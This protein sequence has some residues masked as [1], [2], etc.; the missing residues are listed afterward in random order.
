MIFGTRT[1]FAVSLLLF[2]AVHT[3]AQE[4]PVVRFRAVTPDGAPVANAP[5]FWTPWSENLR[6]TF[7][8]ESERSTTDADGYCTVDFSSHPD[9]AGNNFEVCVE[10]APG[11]AGIVRV[12]PTEKKEGP[13]LIEV[14]KQVP[15]RGRVRAED[16]TPIAGAVLGS[17]WF[18]RTTSDEEGR[19]TV[20]GLG[21]SQTLSVFKD[22]FAWNRI[23]FAK[24]EVDIVLQPGYRITIETVDVTGQSVAGAE[25]RYQ[26][27]MVLSDTEGR[28]QTLPLAAGET[29]HIYA[30]FAREP[31]YI[32]SAPTQ[33]TVVAGQ[34]QVVRLVLTEPERVPPVSISGRVV[35]AG[36]GEPVRARIFAHTAAGEFDYFARERA[37][38]DDQGNFTIVSVSKTEQFL[39]ARPTKSTLYGQDGIVRV[40]CREG[41]VDGIVLNV[42]LG[43]AISGRVTLSDGSNPVPDWVLLSHGEAVQQFYAET[44]HFQFFN[45][46][47]QPT[48]A[49]LRKGDIS[50]PITLPAPG[51]ALRDITI[52]VPAPSTKAQISGQIVNAE[53]A[54]QAGVSLTLRIDPLGQGGN[55]AY[56]N[57]ETDGEGRFTIETPHSGSTAAERITVMRTFTAGGNTE[58]RGMDCKILESPKAVVVE[59]GATVENLRYVIAPPDT[60]MIAGTVWDEAGNLVNANVSFMSESRESVHP[61]GQIQEGHFRFFELPEEKLAIEFTAEKHQAR[62]LEEGRDFQ[63]GDEYIKVILP[64]T[65]YPEGIPLWTTVTGA[66]WT[67]EAVDSA[68]QG[69]S[70][71]MRF[72]HYRRLLDPAPQR[73]VPPPATEGKSGRWRFSSWIPGASP[74]PGLPSTRPSHTCSQ[75]RTTIWASSMSLTLRT[76]P[77]R[78]FRVQRA[79]MKSP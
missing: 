30:A 50:L 34:S 31:T 10:P 66:P 18:P 19:F 43:C 59:P 60:R 47:P 5:I 76:A 26:N 40:D 78:C 7:P 55:A 62:V 77:R 15:I 14:V 63:R 51:N 16:G 38:T 22:G 58:R 23:D 8:D 56:E 6:T 79:A 67:P 74:F 39:L 65:P 45:L 70:I 13:T 73:Q 48:T 11:E 57:A 1:G 24:G 52:E 75:E 41:S 29:I 20:W 2:T 25:V 33:V 32:S 44:G 68:I 69:K 46:P 53:G 28:A 71:R 17:P 35:M 42:A 64:T 37:V 54:P 12:Y 72:D 4:A 36:T 3:A 61:S 49:E 27:A 9:V 21:T